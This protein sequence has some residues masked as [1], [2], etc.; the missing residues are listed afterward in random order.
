MMYTP[1]C[2]I[3]VDGEWIPNAFLNPSMKGLNIL[4]L[5]HAA[6]PF[7]ASVIPLKIPSTTLPPHSLILPSKYF[8]AL[9]KASPISP[10]M[11][12]AKPPNAAPMASESLLTIPFQSMLTR[13]SR[14]FSPTCCQSVFSIATIIVS[15]MPL[16]VLLI[17]CPANDAS[18]DL[19]APFMP[20]DIAL[21]RLFQ[22]KFFAKVFTKPN[23]VLRPLAMVLPTSFQLVVSRNPLRKVAMLLAILLQVFW[24]FF[25][26]IFSSAA[27]SFSP[28][29]EPS[30]VKSAFFHASLISFAR[31]LNWFVT[32]VVWNML[33]ASLSPPIFPAEEPPPE[34]SED[35]S[36]SILLIWSNPIMVRLYFSVAF[37]AL[38]A[39]LA[40]SAKPLDVP[41]R[42][43]A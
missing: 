21:P 2:L 13:T 19:T 27:F 5:I 1:C 36:S 22:W 31:S 8:F 11:N 38:S 24:I 23:A 43:F 35:E 37:E 39:L 4:S 15:R 32:V 17:V 28:T 26:G 16:T 10:P 33:L 20:S 25:H 29:I 14:T 12:A 6:I 18:N 3:T 41:L 42:L 30:S 7:T 40:L 9:V 34:E